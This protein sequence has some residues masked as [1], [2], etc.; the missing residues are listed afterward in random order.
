MVG[1]GKGRFVQKCI[2]H[3]HTT[4]LWNVYGDCEN[5]AVMKGH[6]GAI[7]ELHYSADGR[8][9]VDICYMHQGLFPKDPARGGVKC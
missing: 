6:T 3:T 5:Y 4:V 8:Y 9:T 1:C 7:M 2:T